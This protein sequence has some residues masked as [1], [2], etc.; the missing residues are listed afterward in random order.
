MEQLLEQNVPGIL[1]FGGARMALLDIESGFW[2]VRR[3]VEA[4]IG[5]PLTNSVLQQAGANGGASFAASFGQ[6]EGAQAQGRSFAACV[7]AYQTAGF[8]QF[9][10]HQALWP[11]GRL[12]VRARDAFESWMMQRNGIQA[13]RPVCAYTAGVLVGFVNVVSG[14]RD[15]VCI[16]RTCQA[17]GHEVCEF[18]LLPV[19]EA[20]Q[21]PVVAFTPDPKL[22]R[23]LNLLEMLFERMPMGIAVIDRDYKLVR[24]NPTWAAFIDQYTPSPANQVVPGARIFDL[25]PGT[26]EVLMPLFERV[27]TG[28]TVRQDAVRIESGGVASY[29]DIVL[30]PLYEGERAVGLLNVSIDATE[31]ILAQQ[32]LEQRVEE[33]TRELSTLL[34]ISQDVSSMLDLDALLGTVLDQL[35]TVIDYSGASL[36]ALERD[37]LRILAY[38]GPVPPDQIERLQFPLASSTMNS[39]VIRSGQPVII[40]DIYDDTP[41]ASSFRQGAGDDLRS[42]F[43]YIRCWM[44]IPLMVKGR[45]LG[46]LSLDYDQPDRFNTNS[47]SLALAFA[48]QAAVAM[49]NARLFQEIERR[50]EVAESL[51]DII[52][53]INSDM[54]VEMFLERAVELA[55]KR[56]GAAACVLHQFD[57]D[58]RTISQVASYGTDGVF[59]K[60]GIRPF[61]ALKPSGG[62]AYL[63]A[64]LARQ[65]TFSNYPPLPERV[66]EIR[67]DPTIP[68]CIKVERIAL[69]TRY[70]GSFSVPLFIQNLV[71]GGLVFY[72]TEPQDFTEEQI[73]TGL[74]FADQVAVALENAR[75]HEQDQV[76]QRELQM[77]LDVA[78]VA[79]SSLELNKTLD[80][81]LDLLVDLVGAS[82]AGVALKEE[83]GGALKLQA[84]RPERQVPPEDLARVLKACEE[85][86]ADGKALYIEPD[87]AAG[88][89]EPGALLPLPARDRT[90]GVLA[91]IG[92][93]GSVFHQGQLDL[94]KSIA[95]Q[96]GV[97]VENARLYEQAEQAATAQ[98]RNRLARDLHDAVS[99]TL[100]SAS[101]IADV[102]PKLWQRDPETGQQKLDE[103]RQL[104][105]GALS[106]MRT[107][108]LEL[109]PATL[110]DMD[111]S[112][113]LRHLATAFT[114]R[115]RIPVELDVEGS[116]D[117]PAEV[118]ET[119]YRVAQEALN[120]ISK[121][122]DAGRVSVWL[123]SVEGWLQLGIRDN[124]RGFDPGDISPESL[125][126]GI[127]R[128]RVEGIGAQLKIDTKVGSGTQV[129]LSWK[130]RQE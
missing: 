55:A 90:L 87:E 86:I 68:E 73:Q 108:L 10:I 28:E 69:R 30:S 75:L 71:Y 127:M 50:Q 121:H 3:Q 85:V 88:L 44:G 122:A 82:R 110:I 74:M 80:T 103:L 7:A 26:E 56:L 14:R 76:R 99:Q 119:F 96:L 11:I 40:R 53:M 57:M 59:P 107:L 89:T 120:N 102:L 66:D 16:E 22:G 113:L 129:L 58:K 33:R 116:A 62:E 46:M 38:R 67:R 118:K 39:A 1:Q 47:A 49:E 29:W 17:M 12:T 52:G 19:S 123:Q 109:R 84:L 64:T 6:A 36:M 61:E 42:I 15:V 37:E 93:A 105:R 20:G 60:Q 13:E 21:E 115:N 92:A 35:K 125:G 79:N 91:I 130:E 25:E 95:D 112:D 4:L 24:T 31:R 83:P 65:P 48:N 18:E 128:E 117:P 27:F 78:A 101:L 81:T 124:G 23:Q 98:E 77:L 5:V 72:Y 106:E 9:E 41:E 104:T 63:K 54:P 111:L 32:T 8:G 34:E 97:A 45:V 2:S 94:F 100:F 70:A 126:L 43:K 51:R 114:G